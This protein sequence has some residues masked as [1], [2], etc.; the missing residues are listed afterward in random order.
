MLLKHIT[1]GGLGAK[2]PEAERFFEKKQA[3]LM[4]L[5]HIPHAFWAIWKNYIF[6]IWKPIETIKLLNLTFTY[7]LSPKH[8]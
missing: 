2:T 5:E 4:P 7:N 1:D 6:N 8:V 3:T